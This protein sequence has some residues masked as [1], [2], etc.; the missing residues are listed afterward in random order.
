M[1]VIAKKYN[2][3][4]LS[5]SELVESFCVRTSEFKSLVDALRECT[6]NS[7][8]HQIVI[9]PRGSGKTSLLLRVAVEARTDVALSTRFFPIVFAEES[10]EVATAGE[11]WLECLS[12]LADQV[13]RREGEPDLQ[14]TFQELRALKDDRLLGDRCLGALQDF[15]DREGK[16]LVLVVENLNMMFLDMVDKHA[17]WRLRQTL[18]TEPRILLLASA[19]SRFDEIDDP[20]RALYDLFRVLQLRPLNADECATLWQTVSGQHRE[21]QTIQALRILTGGSPRLLTIVARFGAKLSFSQLMADLMNLVDDHT[22]YFKSHLDALPAQERRVYLALANLWKPATAREIADLSRVEINKCSTYL[23][24][25]VERGAVEVTGGS[26]RRKLYY[27]AERLYNIYY[28]MRR[29]RGPDPLIEALIHFMEAYYSPSELKEFGVRIAHEATDFG[30]QMQ[31]IY[32]TAFA[33]LLELPSLAPHRDELLSRAPTMFHDQLRVPADMAAVP[34]AAQGLANKAFALTDSGRLPQALATWEEVVRRFGASRSPTDCE[35]TAIALVNKGGVLGQLNRPEKAL[36]AWD[37]VVRRFGDSAT[38]TL[39]GPVVSAMVKKGAMLGRLHRLPE[40]LATLDE[41][42]QRFG[43]VDLPIVADRLVEALFC[44]GLALN[45]LDRPQ[46]ALAAWDEVAQRFGQS[47]SSTV[48]QKVAAAALV[49]R[50]YVLAHLDQPEAALAAWTE[51]AQRFETHDAPAILELVA[52]ALTQKSLALARWGRLEE[53]VEAWDVVVRRF[54]ASRAPVLLDAVAEA[55]VNKGVALAKLDRLEDAIADWG[56]VRRRFGA[57]DAPRHR[58]AVATAQLHQARALDDL[59]RPEESLRAW[60]DIVRQFGASETPELLEAV[61]EALVNK[62]ARL[63]L[64]NRQNKAFDTFDEV[65]LRFGASDSPMLLDAVASALVGKGMALAEMNRLADAVNS[66]D[67]VVRRFRTSHTSRRLDAIAD[68][69]ANKGQALAKMNRPD[70]ALNAWDEI[71]R[72][73]DASDSPHLLETV[74]GAMVNK[75]A[76]LAESNRP[77]EAL[78]AWD[79]VVRRFEASDSLALLAAVAG[80]MVNKGNAL[81]ELNRL[82]EA[83]NTWSL[84]VDRFGTIT[85]LAK[86]EPVAISLSNKSAVLAKWGRPDEASAVCDEIVQRFGSTDVPAHR[87]TTELALLRKAEIEQICGRADRAIEVVNEL[88]ERELEVSLAHQLQGQLTRACASLEIGD[89]DACT[90]DLKQVL[91]TLPTL[92]ALPKKVLDTL[93]VLA[94]DLGLQRLHDL[95]QASPAAGL[96]LPL[97]TALKLELGTEPRVAKEIEEVAEDIR[98]DLATYQNERNT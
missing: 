37:E 87:N 65:V 21:L 18:Q 93:L 27:L 79:E 90:R 35:Q 85:P 2:P 76:M 13:P 62:G 97:T 67:E 72:R 3:G 22:E 10:Y 17:G 59:H 73:F 64:L 11:F 88:L 82:E 94:V 48:L 15:S 4:F 6:G 30:T 23:G 8:Q 16:R 25:L 70:D 47:D 50:G 96:L 38:P 69:L 55:L 42:Q 83:M 20:K 53:E 54:G 9:G 77:E 24:R 33:R 19:T 44:K 45:Q 92:D 75:G 98:R 39:L 12:R 81:G 46:E 66:W 63:A 91:T 51:V 78:K 14:R 26:A 43:S 49:C 7:N 40:A 34:T 58:S 84:V 5:D 29:A 61:A 86:S 36:A 57:N 60:D 68:A 80:A 1:G 28:L 56:E 52:T 95:I 74:A 89:T 32:R 71:I 31:L 41:V